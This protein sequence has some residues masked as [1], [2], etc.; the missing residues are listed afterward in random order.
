MDFNEAHPAKLV[1]WYTLV[2]LGT[3]LVRWYTLTRWY[4]GTPSLKIVDLLGETQ[5]NIRY[6]IAVMRRC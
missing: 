3:L 6:P 4:A 1:R 2:H 5:I